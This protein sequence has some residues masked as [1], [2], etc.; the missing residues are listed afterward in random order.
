MLFANKDYSDYYSHNSLI[1]SEDNQQ[2]WSHGWVNTYRRGF[3]ECVVLWE[4]KAK[5]KVNVSKSYCHIEKV[6]NHFI[7]L[8][9]FSTPDCEYN[10]E[11]IYDLV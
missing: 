3:S 8:D 11:N 2:P 10:E 4:K 9:Y 6:Q 5:L 1:S 7:M